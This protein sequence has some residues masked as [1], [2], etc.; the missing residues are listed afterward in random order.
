MT[1]TTEIK[2]QDDTFEVE[3]RCG[4]DPESNDDEIL[5]CGEYMAKKYGEPLILFVRKIEKKGN[6]MRKRKTCSQCGSP[7]YYSDK[8]C[9]G[10]CTH[11]EKRGQ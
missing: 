8:K 2:I 4:K 6:N 10:H 9:K 7:L 5:F 11:C 3:W 1:Y